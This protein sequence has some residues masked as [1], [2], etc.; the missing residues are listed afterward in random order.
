MSTVLVQEVMRYNRLLKVINTSLR[1][2]CKA[3]KGLVVMSGELDAMANS[4]YDS[5]FLL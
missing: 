1:D 4:L 3:I 2:L 5:I